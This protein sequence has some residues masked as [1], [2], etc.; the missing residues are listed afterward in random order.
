MHGMPEAVVP[1]AEVT[2]RLIGML[3]QRLEEA[4]R[5]GQ[6]VSCYAREGM[7]R[8]SFTEADGS[9]TFTM[10]IEARRE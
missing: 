6:R 3:R 7:K 2:E 5:N 10:S 8:G 1:S 4:L 9:F